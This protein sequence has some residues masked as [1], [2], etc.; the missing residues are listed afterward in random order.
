MEITLRAV[1]PPLFS[2]LPQKVAANL[3]SIYKKYSNFD[4]G[5]A[6]KIGTIECQKNFM[7]KKKN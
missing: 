1:K 6:L 3:N 5:F 7:L 4:F 2:I